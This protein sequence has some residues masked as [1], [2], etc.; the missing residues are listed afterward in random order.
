MIWNHPPQ[1]ELTYSGNASTK[2]TL[3]RKGMGIRALDRL[4]RGICD[5]TEII[6]EHIQTQR[7]EL[8]EDPIKEVAAMQYLKKRV[9]NNEEKEHANIMRVLRKWV[10]NNRKF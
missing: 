6:W 9:D 10:S 5:N 8:A 2:F 3:L 1:L 7:L 4:Q